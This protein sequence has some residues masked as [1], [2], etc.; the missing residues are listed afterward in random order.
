MFQCVF[1]HFCDAAP[2]CVFQDPTHHFS[3]PYYS[4]GSNT[5]PENKQLCRASEILCVECFVP[6]GN[7]TYFIYLA[8]NNAQM[9][10]QIAKE[11]ETEFSIHA[12]GGRLLV[13]QSSLASYPPLSKRKDSWY[14]E[15]KGGTQAKQNVDYAYLVNFCASLSLYYLMLEDDIVCASNFVSII[16]RYIKG[17]KRSWTTIAFSRLGYIGKLY[18]NSDLCKLARFLLMFYNAM[19]ADQ[20]LEF[21][22]KSNAQENAIIFRPSLFQ[23]IGETSS[24]HNIQTQLKDPE[25]EEDFGDFGD[26]PPASCFTNIPIFLNYVPDNVCPPGKG[27]FWG[28]NVTSESF[29]TIVF[30]RPI[31]PQKIQ[32][33]TGSAE[34]NTDILYDGYVEQGRFKINSEVHVTCLT[35][36]R[37][38]DFKGGLFEMEDTDNKDDID[39]LR[40]HATAPQ[41]QWLRI[42]RIS[43]WVKKD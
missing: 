17:L 5:N 29:F 27:I 6:I 10:E 20:L 39:C 36:K 8:S 19:P 42:R 4:W 22:H 41:K 16:Q 2:V 30:A 3:S 23:H 31:V 9:N 11:I 38:G 7:D 34:Y 37:L 13:I 28:T 25:F 14:N 40:I 15:E 21:F 26:F 18:H 32:I 43:I 1:K 33:F 24:F 12:R 35:F